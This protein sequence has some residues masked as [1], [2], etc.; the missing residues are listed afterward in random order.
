MSKNN[1]VE[2]AGRD[3]NAD[4][5]TELLCQSARKLT[6]ETVEAEL[7]EYLRGFQDR[8]LRDGRAAVV[9]NGHYP[10]RSIQTGIGPVTVQVPKARAKDG[11]DVPLRIGAA[12]YARRAHWKQLCA[13]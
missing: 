6:Q 5:L 9:G 12:M 8:R 2:F 13:A 10:E 11:R 7:S 3:E 4:P 1:V